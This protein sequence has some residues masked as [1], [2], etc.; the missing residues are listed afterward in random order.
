[1]NKRT[2]NVHEIVCKTF[3]GPRP[4]PE[5]T[6]DHDDRNRSNNNVSNL[7]WA[8]KKQQSANSSRS[9][10]VSAYSMDGTLFKTWDSMRGA[11]KEL[12]LTQ[13]S[14]SYCCNNKNL[15]N[16][17]GGYKWVYSASC[18]TPAI[19]TVITQSSC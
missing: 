10:A 16:V 1:V 13:Q 14:I 18:E 17:Y 8:T 2:V 6:V 19:S 5:Y 11:A 12:G 7:R 4:G 15:T 3:I 9:K